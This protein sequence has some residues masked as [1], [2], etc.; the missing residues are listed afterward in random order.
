MDL[1]EINAG[2]SVHRHAL[3]SMG[4][5]V[6]FS[7]GDRSFIFDGHNGRFIDAVPAGVADYLAGGAAGAVAADVLR[8][9]GWLEWL[10]SYREGV[11]P[12]LQQ[13]QRQAVFLQGAAPE[14]YRSEEHTAELQS[15]QYLVCRLLL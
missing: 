2:V 14:R 6:L 13:E 9:T 12:D 11:R 8:H 10:D 1:T 15:R 3:D 4:R 5:A 7:V